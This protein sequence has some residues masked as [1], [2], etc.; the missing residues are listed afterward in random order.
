MS[1]K[2]YQLPY[3][4]EVTGTFKTSAAVSYLGHSCGIENY[5]IVID[6]AV[7]YLGTC[8]EIP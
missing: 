3:R 1:Y 8:R 7:R 5:E 6:V 2:C 4:K